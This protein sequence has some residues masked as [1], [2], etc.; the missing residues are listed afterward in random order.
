MNRTDAIDY[1]TQCADDNGTHW[2]GG[3]SYTEQDCPTCRGTNDAGWLAT[4][5]SRYGHTSAHCAP[6]AYQCAKIEHV[7]NRE[8]LSWW[9]GLVVNDS[10]TPQEHIREYV[11]GL[12]GADID[13]MVQGYLECQLW[14]QLDYD[15]PSCDCHA[16][17][18]QNACHNYT[19]DEKYSVDDIAPEYVD[20]IRDELSAIAT[21]H[22]LAV[23]MFLA[24]TGKTSAPGLYSD[25]SG[26]FGH[27]FYLTREGHGAGFWDRGLGELGDYLTQLAKWAGSADDLSDYGDTGTLS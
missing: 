11:I 23:R 13:A 21:E 22:P 19:L 27:D 20:K 9:M 10:E 12:S 14:A 16:D 4:P 1:L 3:S 8:N 24:R 6:T 7:V 18:P 15:N 25:A 17:D 2:S 26:S 5:C